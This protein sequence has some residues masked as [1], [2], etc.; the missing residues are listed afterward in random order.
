MTRER[1]LSRSLPV[2]IDLSALQQVQS[3]LGATQK[4]FEMAY[5]RALKRTAVTLQKLA[6]AEMKAGV[7]PRSMNQVRRRLMHFRHGR[8]GNKMDEIKLF[9]GLNAIKVKDLKGR[10]K[11]KVLPH[12]DIRDPV[13]GRYTAGEGTRRV[14]APPTFTPA[15]DMPTQTFEGGFVG[16]TRK[17]RRTIFQK[18]GRSLREAEVSIYAPMLD[19]IEDKVFAEAMEI[20]MHHFE[21]DLRG[22]VRQRIDI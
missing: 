13:T 20:F 11:G 10:I 1:R 7:S 8:S 16:K 21:S 14:V 6:R 15:G 18:S 22:R 4:Q 12:H 9:F 2:D 19:R 3:V 5:S 17:G